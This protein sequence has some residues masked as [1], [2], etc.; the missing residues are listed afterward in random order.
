MDVDRADDV[1]PHLADEHHAGDIQRVFVGDPEAVDELGLLA[2]TLQHLADLWPTAVDHHRLETDR[3][4]Q[5]DV[6][7]EGGR[8]RRVDHG[9]AA[10][11]HHH[12][13]TAEPLD[14]GQ[15]LHQ[16][17]GPSA[18]CESAVGQLFGLGHERYPALM[19]M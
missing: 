7:R 14:V 3:A 19:S 2:E 18:G 8:Q 16:C 17:A 6:F 12:D 5:H 4:Q 1:A 10:V 15:R 11:L 9:V 13:G